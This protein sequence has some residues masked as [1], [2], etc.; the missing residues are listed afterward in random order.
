MVLAM[1]SWVENQIQKT[2]PDLMKIL[3]L[4][5]G[6]DFT[7]YLEVTRTLAGNRYG[8]TYIIELEL[9]SDDNSSM[10]IGLIIKH[11]YEGESYFKY[12]VDTSE[13]FI[14]LMESRQNSWQKKKLELLDNVKKNLNFVPD[15]IF[16]PKIL[17][18]DEETRIIQFETLPRFVT[19]PKSG[20]SPNEQNALLGYALAR[21]HGFNNPV[22]PKLSNYTPWFD[23]LSKIG[24]DK[25]S[26][27]HWQKILTTS[28]GGISYIFGDYSLESIQYNSLTP[29][30]GR[31]DSLCIFDPILIPNGDRSE[32]IGYLLAIISE[33][34]VNAAM[35]TTTN[36]LSTRKILSE[37]TEMVLSKTAPAILKA[38]MTLCPEL[39]ELYENNEIPIDFFTAGFLLQ[40][41]QL[42]SDHNYK[43]MS[44]ILTV[45]GNQLIETRPLV[46]NIKSLF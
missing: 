10:V 2:V 28:K 45:M 3:S 8:E 6:I 9:I 1:T 30:K 23:Y 18:K 31:L 41:A 21:M 14:E 13:K 19:R 37:T 11:I 35:Q 46:E 38:Y 27:D 16:A 33:K 34:Y 24:V 7:H 17:I 5:T 26:L 22:L 39:P 25:K 20:I 29:G 44:D 36:D 43:K 4:Q 32:D 12:V 42:Y 15:S 40:K